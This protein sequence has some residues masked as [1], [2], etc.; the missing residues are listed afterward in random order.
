MRANTITIWLV[1]AG[2]LFMAITTAMNQEP[3]PIYTPS[4]YSN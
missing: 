2:L 4:R 1:V 3:E